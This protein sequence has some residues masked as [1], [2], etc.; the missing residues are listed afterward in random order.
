MEQQIL[1]LERDIK[2]FPQSENQ[3]DKFVEK[4][5]ISFICLSISFVHFCVCL[6]VYL[7]LY[8]SIYYV[9]SSKLTGLF[10]LSGWICV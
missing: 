6:F 5:T 9:V 2:K 3:H 4:M 7:S 1:H 10:I 8:P